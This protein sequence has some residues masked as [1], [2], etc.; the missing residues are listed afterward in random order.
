MTDSFRLEEHPVLFLRPHVSEPHSWIGHIPFAYLLVDLVR[1]QLLVELGTHSGNSYLAFCQA[2]AAT[3]SGTR[4]VAVDSWQG[5]EHAQHY[6]ESVYE[7]LKAYHDPRYGAFSQLHR[8]MFDEAVSS[9]DDETI[10]VLHIDGLHTY[11]AVRHDFET[12]LPK[13][14][15]RAIVLFHDT[16]VHERGFGVDRYF[17]ELCERY[18]GF[19]FPHSNGLGVLVVGHQPPGRFKAF[20]AAYSKRPQEFNRFFAQLAPLPAAGLDRAD[21]AAPEIECRLYYRSADHGYTED[22]TVGRIVKDTG[23]T[24]VAFEL[25]VDAEFDYIRVDPAAVPGVY[26]LVSVSFIDANGAILHELGNVA[27]RVTVINGKQLQPRQPSWIRWLETGRD[28]YVELRMDDLGHR[29]ASLGPVTVVVVVD[30]ELVPTDAHTLAVMETLADIDRS[31]SRQ[32]LEVSHAIVAINEGFHRNAV[33]FEQRL[34]LLRRQHGDESHGLAERIEA[35]RGMLAACAESLNH[36]A[37]EVE[38]LARDRIGPIEAAISGLHTR[39]SAHQAALEAAISGHHELARQFE[40]RSGAHQA[41]LEFLSARI[42]QLTVDSAQ[43][44]TALGD[45]LGTMSE[46]RRNQGLL[47]TWAQHRSLSYWWRRL[48]GRGN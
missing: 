34:Q 20:V 10:D 47:L 18:E 7:T 6:S 33:S 36:V 30:Y 4:C 1:P 21:F 35:A 2:V 37:A 40:T 23:L 22:K 11:E 25:P 24:R 45:L 43:S 41:Q 16:A 14:S 48:V 9:F 12:W 8:A 39:S 5:D 32:T 28:P 42:G 29:L 44:R 46:I 19:S 13:L 27:D 31:A 38:G 15:R 3:Q 17:A 26:G